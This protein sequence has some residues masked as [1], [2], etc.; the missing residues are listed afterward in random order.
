[1]FRPKHTI[2]SSTPIGGTTNIALRSHLLRDS[3]RAAGPH[4]SPT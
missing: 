2:S 1:V 4:F 3:A